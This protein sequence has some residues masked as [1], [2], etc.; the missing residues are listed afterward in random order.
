MRTNSDEFKKLISVINIYVVHNLAVEEESVVLSMA[1]QGMIRLDIKAYTEVKL[2]H[3]IQ[4]EDIEVVQSLASMG[5]LEEAIRDKLVVEEACIPF[6]AMHTTVVDI[7]GL[8]LVDRLVNVL[9]V[10][11]ILLEF[12]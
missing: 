3:P 4:Q 5:S 1:A 8:H 11:Y 6:M 10:S 12:V 2:E 7:K 9:V